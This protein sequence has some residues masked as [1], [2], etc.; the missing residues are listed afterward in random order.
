MRIAFLIGCK[1]YD[2]ADIAD[3][4]Y[5]DNDADYFAKT[6]ASSCGFTDDE[7]ILLSNS[8]ENRNLWPTKSNIIRELSQSSKL[9]KRSSEIKLLFFFF[10]GHGFHSIYDG[11]DYL[12]PQDAVSTA[13]EDTAIPFDTLIK[14]LRSWDARDVIIFL[15]ACRAAVQGGKDVI[16]ENWNRINVESLYSSGMASFCSCSPPTKIL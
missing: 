10:S 13:L 12:V 7:I 11:K 4:K 2:D 16:I 1:K 3:L 14:Y 15:D 5:A 9:S 8:H 6:I